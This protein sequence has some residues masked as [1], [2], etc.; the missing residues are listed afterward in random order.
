[1]EKIFQLHMLKKQATVGIL[2]SEEVDLILK[3]VR[4]DKEGYYIFKGQSS[5]RTLQFLSSLH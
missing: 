1:M 3:F 2:I 4:I 5:K